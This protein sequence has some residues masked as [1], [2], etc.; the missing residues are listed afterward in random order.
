MLWAS[1]LEFV[2]LSRVRRLNDLL[3]IPFEFEHLKRL[4]FSEAIKIKN[5]EDVRLKMLSKATKDEYAHLWNKGQEQR[6]CVDEMDVD[7]D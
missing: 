7:S 6:D 1:G 2:A 4:N 3:L 5:V